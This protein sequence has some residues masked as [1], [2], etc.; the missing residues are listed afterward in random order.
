MKHAIIVLLF[1]G[2]FLFA[3][4][5]QKPHVILI[6]FDGFRHD[7]V[8]KYNLPHFKSFISKGASSEALIPSF[9]SKTFPNH[10]TLVTGLYP[11]NHGLIDNSFYDQKLDARYT[12]RNRELVENPAFY[13]G[14]P[15]WQLAQK[16]G[17]PTASFFWVGSELPIQGEYPTFYKRYDE[18]VPN[19]NRIDQVLMWLNLPVEE[20]PRFISL[21]FSMVDTEGHRTGPNSEELKKTAVEADRLLGYLI[22]ELKKIDLPVNV[23]IVSDHGMTELRQEEKTFLTLSKLFNTQDTS[24]VVVN[25]GTHAHVYTSKKDSLYTVLKN[26]EKNYTVY[27][28]EDLPGRW[29]YTHDRVGDLFIEAHKGFQLQMVNRTFGVTDT[30]PFIGVHGYDPYTF[31]DMYGIFYAMGPNIKSGKRVPAFENIHVYPFIATL[32]GLRIPEIDGSAEVL[33][34]LYK[35]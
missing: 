33:K 21:Y 12:M 18:S 34:V 25:S 20:R 2:Q 35:K 7:Y 9:P 23:I 3:Q 1:C 26:Q 4:P 13:G 24:I 8:E 27:K 28:K 15:L 16:Q 14:T 5:G 29:H 32:L 31:P 22:S 6:S 17:I 10:Y 11:G 19:I 30:V